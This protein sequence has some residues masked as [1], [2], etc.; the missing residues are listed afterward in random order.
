MLTTVPAGGPN[1]G[2]GGGKGGAQMRLVLSI[3][4]GNMPTKS[5]GSTKE[6]VAKLKNQRQ[7]PKDEPEVVI[8][9]TRVPK[10]PTGLDMFGQAKLDPKIATMISEDQLLAH[11][12]EVNRLKKKLPETRKQLYELYAIDPFPH[13]GIQHTQ[14]S[15]TDHHCY[16]YQLREDEASLVAVCRSKLDGSCYCRFATS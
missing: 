4:L 14:S 9:F 5:F 13:F 1:T 10:R 6:L 3:Y 16:L 7:A 12:E 15:L 8:N 11:L 2:G